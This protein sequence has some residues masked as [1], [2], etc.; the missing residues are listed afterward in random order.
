MNNEI[1]LALDRK[2]AHLKISALSAGYG[3]FLVLCQWLGGRRKLAATLLVLA[4]LAMIIVPGVMLGGSLADDIQA[5]VGAFQEGRLQVPPPASRPSR[6]TVART[7]A[8]CSPPITEIRL[9]GQVQRK[10]G[11]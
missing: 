11:E 3:P 8:A 2:L 1:E 7:L 10:R 6:R 4:L 9:F 5:V